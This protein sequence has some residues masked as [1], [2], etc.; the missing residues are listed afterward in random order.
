MI[1]SSSSSM[2]TSRFFQTVLPLSP[3]I[4][5]LTA[6]Y[7]SRS[8]QT[9]LGIREDTLSQ[10]L[11]SANVRPEGRYLVVDDTGGLVTGAMVE[12]MGAEGRILLLTETDS[13]PAWGVLNVM[14]FSEDEMECVKWMNWMEAEESYERRELSA[15]VRS[16]TA[17][18]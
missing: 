3:T 7:L 1:S 12:R 15:H 4:P 17:H 9:I 5:N 6:H 14:N 8:P 13:P 11:N 18:T 2:L 10:L 16:S